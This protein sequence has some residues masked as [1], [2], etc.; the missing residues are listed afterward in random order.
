MQHAKHIRLTMALSL[1]LE[2]QNGVA[3]CAPGGK[4]EVSTAKR[5]D[6]EEAVWPEKARWQEV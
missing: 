3:A 2:E 4:V 5:G 6:R 1:P